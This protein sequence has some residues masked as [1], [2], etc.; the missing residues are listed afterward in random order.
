[1]AGLAGATG[2][3]IFLAVET[4]GFFTCCFGVKFGYTVYFLAGLEAGLATGF[5]AGLVSDLTAYF[6]VGLATG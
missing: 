2:L 1:L 5:V 4:D 6:G 3:L